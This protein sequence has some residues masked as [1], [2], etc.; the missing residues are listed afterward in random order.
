MY[1]KQIVTPPQS[2]HH[3]HLCTNK[4]RVAT[5]SDDP[6]W[7]HD[8]TGLRALAVLPVL[9][10]HAF[11]YLIPSGFFGVDIFFVISGYLISGIIFRGLQNNSFSYL[12]FY[13][14][15]I[16]RIIPNLLLVLLAVL[17]MGWFV[18]TAK[19]YES[20]RFDLRASAFF[21][22]NFHLLKG[23]DYWAESSQLLPLLHLWSLS[24]EEQF[25]IVFPLI[26]ALLWKLK[27]RKALG[28][29]VVIFTLY[30]FLSCIHAHLPERAFYWPINR[31][32][33]LGTGIIVSYIECF[34]LWDLKAISLKLRQFM[35]LLGLVMI[36]YA[37]M[38]YTNVHPSFKTL[39]P[40]IGAVL[41]IVAG[42]EC[43]I[44]RLL[45]LKFLVFIGL[46]SYSLY[47]WHWPLLAYLRLNGGDITT[48]KL[49][50]A[51]FVTLIIS[52][53]VY[54]TIE[55]PIRHSN[56]H[57]GKLGVSSV[58]II[59]LLAFSVLQVQI[60]KI[61][62]HYQRIA[63]G[64]WSS[65]L[66]DTRRW[67]DWGQCDHIKIADLDIV[68]SKPN[69]R[70]EILMIGDSHTEQY[71]YRMR[72][73]SFMHDIDSGI[74]FHAINGG[75][76]VMLEK[77]D[78]MLKQSN[79]KAIIVS[80]KWGQCEHDGANLKTIA[81]KKYQELKQ[82][83]PHIKFY[84]VLDAPWDGGYYNEEM[85]SF[86]IATH[87]DRVFFSPEDVRH[88][89]I[90]Y[91]SQNSWI[92]GNNTVKAMLGNV[93]TII[94]IESKVCPNKKCDIGE[95]YRDDDHLKPRWL[96]DYA[97]WLDRVFEECKDSQ[98]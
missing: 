29:F 57:F 3:Y 23:S 80:A 67:I 37:M 40:V 97:I 70:P 46:I 82:K 62:R 96:E 16:K 44:N 7:R 86:D 75:W 90:D 71:F 45:S 95:R 61:D 78:L 35:S 13:R 94:E 91:P 51:L 8:I 55:N 5:R 50:L 66:E 27:S 1:R 9:L 64:K 53:V 58:L 26:C 30:S 33:E 28:I 93:A 4:P 17:V 34:R 20:L 79:I 10:F 85:G 6:S 42:R 81:L 18:M 98:R 74:L 21:Y 24:I 69:A 52:S 87:L 83:Y 84:A 63:T 60:C 72:K 92:I 2:T 49:T 56:W 48:L 32:W 19:E 38:T 54:V 76:M 43:L 47:L 15:R 11:P 36:I 41:I 68:V 73:L 59:L 14:R 31:F 12:E 65:F 25:Y 22:Q 39:I 77:L 89:L 88:F